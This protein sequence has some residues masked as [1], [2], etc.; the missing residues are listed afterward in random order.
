MKLFKYAYAYRLK[1]K[2]QNDY[3]CI[4]YPFAGMY[5][6]RDVCPADHWFVY[7]TIRYKLAYNRIVAK[8][9][10]NCES[11]LKNSI[12]TGTSSN[13]T[14]LMPYINNSAKMH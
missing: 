14:S 3:I 1:L 5:Y 2:S 6:Y 4:R 10:L 7:L 8:L 9:Q 11:T 13:L 12:P